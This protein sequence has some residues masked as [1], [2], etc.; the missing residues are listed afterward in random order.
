MQATVALVRISILTL[1]ALAGCGSAALEAR[2]TIPHPVG[3]AARG[4][5]L[6]IYTRDAALPRSIQLQNA[7][8]L[9][10][11]TSD[12]VIFHVRLVHAW[13]EV[14]D[15]T[16]WTVWLE[17]EDGRRIAP[18]SQANAQLARVAIEWDR[19]QSPAVKRTNRK[20][21]YYRRIPALNVYQ[22][23]L[24]VEFA[25]PALVFMAGGLRLVVRRRDDVDLR[26]DWRFAD[27]P[28]RF[29]HYGHTAGDEELGTIIVPGV[30][31]RVAASP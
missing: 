25:A 5:P 30:A 11:A 29:E 24:D 15:P 27:G 13:D 8:A 12:R 4:T 10:T 18:A 1:V 17:D 9:V 6:Y 26:W 14:A 21:R 7:A 19:D 2:A 23:E 3:S 28:A 20:S 31:T 22:G 16:H